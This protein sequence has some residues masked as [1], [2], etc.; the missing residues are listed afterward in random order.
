VRET[1]TSLQPVGEEETHS[2]DRATGASHSAGRA[3]KSLITQAVKNLLNNAIKYSPERT[4]VTFQQR[5]KLKACACVLKIVVSEFRGGEGTRVGQVLSRVRE[6]QEKDEES[7]DWDYRL[8]VKWSS[9]TAG[10]SNSIR[11]KDVARSSVLHCRDCKRFRL[12]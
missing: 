1:I 11:K 7:T 9:N 5:S 10:E 12:D 8:C 4:T 3:D 2:P 6:G